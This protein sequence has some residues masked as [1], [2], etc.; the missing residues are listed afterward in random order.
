[1][2]GFGFGAALDGRAGLGE[3]G[4]AGTKITVGEGEAGIGTAAKL[5]DSNGRRPHH[6]AKAARTVSTAQPTA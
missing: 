1:M 4:D 5:D 2:E 6:T 3:A